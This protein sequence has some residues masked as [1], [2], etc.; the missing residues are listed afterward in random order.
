ML[1]KPV[2]SMPA[3]EAHASNEAVENLLLLVIGASI[4]FHFLTNGVQDASS[5]SPTHV[6]KRLPI[7][8]LRAHSQATPGHALWFSCAQPLLAILPTPN[9]GATRSLM[10][11][12]LLHTRTQFHAGFLSSLRFFPITNSWTGTACIG[13]KTRKQKITDAITHIRLSTLERS[14]Q[15]H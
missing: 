3:S 12:P 1:R 6:S 2:E 7:D 14:H 11:S 8:C 10:M 5:K 4:R 9:C 13:R 15:Q